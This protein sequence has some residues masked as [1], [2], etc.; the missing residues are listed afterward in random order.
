MFFFPPKHDGCSFGCIPLICAANLP[1]TENMPV[2]LPAA[3]FG[4][5]Y[6]IVITLFLEMGAEFADT[7]ELSRKHTGE[8]V[9]CHSAVVFLF[10]SSRTNGN[11]MDFGDGLY[12]CAPIYNGFGINSATLR[13]CLT[14]CD[15][16]NYLMLNAPIRVSLPPIFKSCAA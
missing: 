11:V 5:A 9:H 3:A 6:L 13:L 14:N 7:A 4:S 10:T 12:V 2:K 15:P 1:V 8:S 16:S